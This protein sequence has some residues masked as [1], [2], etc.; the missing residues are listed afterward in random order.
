MTVGSGPVSTRSC[1]FA[2][3]ITAAHRQLDSAPLIL[4]WDSGFIAGTG[5]G[6]EPS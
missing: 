3:L 2:E 1:P 6:L 5:L 4:V